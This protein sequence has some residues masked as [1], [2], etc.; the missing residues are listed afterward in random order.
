[1]VETLAIPVPS[2]SG[3]RRPLPL[4]AVRSTG[5]LRIPHTSADQSIQPNQSLSLSPPDLSYSNSSAHTSHDPEYALHHHN[6][7]TTGSSSTGKN[8]SWKSAYRQQVLGGPAS[9]L[10]SKQQGKQR[11][12]LDSVF[13]TQLPGFPYLNSA[14]VATAGPALQAGY[15]HDLRN[16]A[17]RTWSDRS[18]SAT[19]S[20]NGR[21]VSGSA[22][23]R[24]DT[25]GYY[26][27][28]SNTSY[29]AGPAG[30]SAA[31]NADIGEVDTSC[32]GG[33]NSSD[34]V[35]LDLSF[36]MDV[37]RAKQAQMQ[38]QARQKEAARAQKGKTSTA[39]GGHVGIDIQEGYSAD[40]ETPLP[41][42]SGMQSDEQRRYRLAGKKH[43]SRSA[44]E[45]RGDAMGAQ[46][47]RYSG[48]SEPGKLGAVPTAWARQ[49][50]LEI[51]MAM[52]FDENEPIGWSFAATPPLS[53]A[54]LAAFAEHNNPSR[55]SSHF[56]G[57]GKE[58]RKSF[59]ASEL[60]RKRRP[61]FPLMSLLDR[62]LHRSTGDDKRSPPGKDEDLTIST[63]C[64]AEAT[65]T[66]EYGDRYFE[67]ALP[68]VPVM[69]AV[70]AEAG[71]QSPG[72]P[73]TTSSMLSPN[74]VS[75]PGTMT[76]DCTP[77]T[78]ACNSPKSQNDDLPTPKTGEFDH[79]FSQY[80][81]AAMTE[82]AGIR[83][84][85]Q[86][87]TAAL[88][89]TEKDRKSEDAAFKPS[90]TR[91]S[92]SI[93]RF[94]FVSNLFSPFRPASPA[95]TVIPIPENVSGEEATRAS[96]EA[97]PTGPVSKVVQTASARAA[98]PSSADSHGP[99]GSSE[100]SHAL[101]S[102]PPSPP[103]E[104]A[105]PSRLS[106][107]IDG[108]M[109][110]P[111]PNVGKGRLAGLGLSFQSGQQ[112]QS[113]LPVLAFSTASSDGHGSNESHNSQIARAPSP[114]VQVG[115]P[116]YPAARS[117]LDGPRTTVRVASSE[118][119][120]PPMSAPATTIRFHDADAGIAS[121]LDADGGPLTASPRMQ[122]HPSSPIPTTRPRQLLAKTSELDLRGRIEAMKPAQVLFVAA[123][124]FGPW[125]FVLGGWGLRHLD[126]ECVSVKGVRCRCNDDAE[127]CTCQAE[128]Y[129]QIRLSGGKKLVAQAAAAGAAGQGVKHRLDKYIMANRIAALLSGTV[130]LV[131][132]IT[133][134]IAL[135]RAW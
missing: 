71:R 34:E 13:G 4:R 132:A 78:S 86:Q 106:G 17:S 38:L 44:V 57:S 3:S 61:S 99:A 46:H 16:R 75:S 48:R 73:S 104:G 9:A 50:G 123:F 67:A 31:A 23:T 125:C 100:G 11:I 101:S 39:A 54:E 52:P 20:Y 24:S 110:R 30:G 70:F 65:P 131:L 68:P 92:S 77:E 47:H 93:F 133:A 1:M 127:T 56:D 21:T 98:S 128:T 94:P 60:L 58:R 103:R 129:R 81:M 126:G 37:L 116:Q 120:R 7:N 32:S 89:A 51:G 53:P 130:G 5:S 108:S 72:S 43:M 35:D 55:F 69:P 79:R 88:A 87:Q 118:A 76:A 84:S 97:T 85:L 134:L 59:G 105:K 119:R 82:G 19:G 18:A 80:S 83:D 63:F 15:N 109:L 49:P 28:T 114:R 14:A 107:V 8:D 36:D 112:R 115:G 74:L 6:A 117:S 41:S 45:L 26:S 66:Q 111:G 2:G 22:R 96:G 124:I 90:H 12:R 64:N 42:R 40:E 135:G 33:S 95:A 91:Q 25:I 10:S 29:G 27:S 62:A 121:R 102:D 113:S 122:H